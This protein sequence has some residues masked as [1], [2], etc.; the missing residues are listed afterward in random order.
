M[1]GHSVLWNL[2][3]EGDFCFEDS[4]VYLLYF[5]RKIWDI[6]LHHTYLLQGKI[7]YVYFIFYYDYCTSFYNHYD[8]HNIYTYIFYFCSFNPSF[9]LLYDRSLLQLH[10]FFH[11]N[12]AHLIQ[13]G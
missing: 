9:L 10:F 5:Y 13:Y 1:T 7:Q 3:I 8:N 4:F 11:C 2:K 12:K 6:S